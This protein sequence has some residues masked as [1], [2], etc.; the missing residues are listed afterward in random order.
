MK[1][2][3]KMAWIELTANIESIIVLNIEFSNLNIILETMNSQTQG[4]QY[5]INLQKEFIGFWMKA[6]SL[7]S[8]KVTI[9]VF[10]R[11]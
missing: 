7:R 6:E 10:L 11:V 4:Y 3:N 9:T 5:I 8:I 1:R 2:W